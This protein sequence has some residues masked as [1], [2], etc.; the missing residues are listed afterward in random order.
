M[1]GKEKDGEA[2]DTLFRYH[3]QKCAKGS[4]PHLKEEKIYIKL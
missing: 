2:W 4:I 1:T 3:N